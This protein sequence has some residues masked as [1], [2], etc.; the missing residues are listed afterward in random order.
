MKTVTVNESL[1]KQISCNEI[2]DGLT[3]ESVVIRIFLPHIYQIAV[4]WTQAIHQTM[5][6]GRLEENLLFD[7]SP[8]AM[9]GFEYGTLRTEYCWS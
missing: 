3:H 2:W 7:S 5:Y 1:I 9:L 4:W 6:Q 8:N